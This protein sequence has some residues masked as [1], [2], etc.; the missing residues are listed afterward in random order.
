MSKNIQH[1]RASL[2]RL[3]ID[4]LITLLMGWQDGY[5]VKIPLVLRTL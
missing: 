5:L 2:S 1:K 4:P 3:A